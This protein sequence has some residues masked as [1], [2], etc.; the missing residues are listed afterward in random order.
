MTKP[1][2]LL[3]AVAFPAVARA[4]TDGPGGFVWRDVL[5][6]VESVEAVI[7]AAC[8]PAKN[9]V[10][11]KHVYYSGRVQGVGFRATTHGIS[12]GRGVTGWVKNLDD[13]RV[14]MV[15]EGKSDAVAGFMAEIAR[16]MSRN[17]TDTHVEDKTPTGRYKAFTIE[18]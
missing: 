15:V 3:A 8:M 5:N 6:V 4:D 10:V 18:Y 13:G 14:E 16:V 2:I 9:A 12:R 7:G 11:A 17:I 1:I